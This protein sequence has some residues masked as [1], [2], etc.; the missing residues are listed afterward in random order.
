V[1]PFIASRE[2]DEHIWGRGAC[3]TKG[4][5]ASMITALESLLAEGVRNVGIL[6]VV[7]EEVDSIGARKANDLKPGSKYLING[8]PQMRFTLRGVVPAE[9]IAAAVAEV[10]TARKGRKGRILK[11][12]DMSSLFG[13][14]LDADADGPP[15]PVRRAR[16]KAAKKK[17]ARKKKPAKTAKATKRKKKTVKKPAAT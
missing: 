4:I 7:G 2:D 11:S 1:P 17:V 3:D 15:R 9:M 16:K 14:E 13:I 6:F 8:E 10:P 5:I 12:N